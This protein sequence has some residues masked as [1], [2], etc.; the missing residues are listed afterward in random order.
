[1]ADR[2][3][4]HIAASNFRT[5]HDEINSATI[6]STLL[7]H[8][9][10]PH[11]LNHTTMAAAVDILRFVGRNIGVVVSILFSATYVYL[12]LYHPRNPLLPLMY[13]ALQWLLYGIL[14]TGVGVLAFFAIAL[15]VVTPMVNMLLE[16]VD[17]GDE[18]TDTKM[19]VARDNEEGIVTGS[20]ADQK[21]LRATLSDVGFL[22]FIVLLLVATA[23]SLRPPE[24]SVVNGTWTILLQATTHVLIVAICILGP[25]LILSAPVLAVFVMVNR[26]SLEPYK[27]KWSNYTRTYTLVVAT[28]TQSKFGQQTLSPLPF[29]TSTL[30]TLGISAYSLAVLWTVSDRVASRLLRRAVTR[31]EITTNPPP[32][33]PLQEGLLQWANFVVMPFA[34]ALDGYAF[35]G[36]LG[37]GIKVLIAV[38]LAA[39]GIVVLDF[40]IYW[41]YFW[42]QSGVKEPLS[43]SPNEAK[44]VLTPS[45]IMG[46]LLIQL[47]QHHRRAAAAA[48]PSIICYRDKSISSS[49][50]KTF[51]AFHHHIFATWLC[52]PRTSHHPNPNFTHFGLLHSSFPLSP[53]ETHIFR[54]NFLMLSLITSAQNFDPV[55]HI[56]AAVLT[57]LL[58]LDRHLN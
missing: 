4:M 18:T 24:M 44:I 10:S 28:P 11:T 7:S 14:Y 34:M 5:L 16:G 20:P 23:F 49:L 35:N 37:T 51:F 45:K 13:R 58:Y 40:C 15:F 19:P 6:S 55:A 30:Q 25:I 48:G 42:T 53:T 36:Q 50:K 33:R 27:T 3:Y 57:P 56:T 1:M 43:D 41:V 2:H 46:V 54:P 31:P 47:A 21:G 38:T 29:L 12:G 17:N 32:R 52:S 39:F 9:C 22:A 8:G 26:L